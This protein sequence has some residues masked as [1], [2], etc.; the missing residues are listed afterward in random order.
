MRE[1]R[2]ASAVPT[3]LQLQSAVGGRMMSP[4][5]STVPQGVSMNFRPSKSARSLPATAT[6][7]HA[8]GTAAVG[9][10]VIGAAALGALAVG[11]L[12][13]GRLF[14]GR[15]RIRR[16][17]IDELVVRRIRIIEQLTPPPASM[18]VGEPIKTRAEAAK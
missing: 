15:A 7:A 1:L 12:A 2:S 11:A 4:R 8:V 18:P 14:V 5:T 9:S 13:I 10:I 3:F 17:E 16:L 6:G